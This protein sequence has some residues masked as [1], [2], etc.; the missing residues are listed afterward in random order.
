MT[1]VTFSG[2]SAAG[3]LT[4]DEG[5]ITDV[6]IGPMTG[7]VLRADIEVAIVTCS[8]SFAAGVLRDWF[9]LLMVL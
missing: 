5:R 9:R 7:V 6:L 1:V 3:V 2:S 8:D 4:V